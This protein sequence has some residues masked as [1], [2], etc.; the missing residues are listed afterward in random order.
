MFSKLTKE[1]FPEYSKRIKDYWVKKE[2]NLESIIF[3]IK[4]QQMTIYLAVCCEDIVGYLMAKPIAGGVC[5]GVW[6]AVDESH[7]KKGVAS[8][9]LKLWE[10]DAKKQG[11]H[12]LHLCA[13]KRN[14]EFYFQM[15]REKCKRVISFAFP[16]EC[17]NTLQVFGGV[18]TPPKTWSL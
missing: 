11:M 17:E 6:L 8:G 1:R 2:F 10:K 3:Q 5:L 9:L 4:D 16:S 13:D 18:N 7:E 15:K 14:V 12:K